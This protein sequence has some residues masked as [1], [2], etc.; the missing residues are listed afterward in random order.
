MIKNYGSISNKINHI[1]HGAD[2]NPE[3]W[4]HTPHV[5]EEDYK[6][7]KL[8]N[9]N[10]M[11]VNVFGWS[12]IE[13]EEGVYNFESLDNTLDN[14]Y[15]NGIYAIIATPSGA[16]PNWLSKKYEETNRVSKNRVRHLAGLRHNHCFTSHVYREKVKN[17]NTLIA[18]RYKN[19]P[20]LLMWH[21]SNEYEGEC[22]C[23]LCQNAFREWL[24]QKYDNSLEKL[25][26]AWWTNFWS[27][28]YTSWDEIESPSPIGEKYVHG[29]N[30]D[31]KR[32]V[33]YQ[34]VDF[35]KKEI[36]V[37][38]EIAP[39][40]P[41]TTNT[42]DYVV[43][44]RGLNY[45]DF[46]PHIDVISWDNYPRWHEGKCENWK[47]AVKTG[48]IHDI[49]RSLKNGQPFMMMESS[50]SA[51]NWQPVA[52]LR[53]PG[54]QNL[55]S[56]QAVA[57]GSDTVQYFQWRKSLGSFEKFHGAVV[58]HYA[59]TNTRVFKE[60]SAIGEDLKKLDG[61]IGTSVEPQ[62][63]II[64]DWENFW[65]IDDSQA[66]NEKRKEYFQTCVKHYT[67]FWKRGI[68]ANVI[69]MDC[70]LSKYKMVI[71][72]MLYMI[73]DGVGEKIEKFVKIGGVFVTTYWSGIV[74]ET[75][76][77]FTNG[78]PGPLKKVMGIWSEEIDA[79]Y[80]GEF[81]IVKMISSE[82]EYKAEV[83]CDL[84]HCEG[85]IKL[86]EYKTDFYKGYP[87]LT[88]NEFGKGYGYYIASRNCEEF[89]NDFYG[90][91]IIKHNI[92]PVMNTTLPEGVTINV[93][94]DEKNTFYFMQNYT[95]NDKE[96]ILDDDKYVNVLTKNKVGKSIT[97]PGYS[98]KILE[99]RNRK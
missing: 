86:A 93:R 74:N 83:F 76:L 3:Q 89:L 56:M 19:H 5:I 66:P 57:H 98:Y 62:V 29:L 40:I 50:P 42:H 87:A 47:S 24:K 94:E 16:R 99:K 44:E 80:D 7:M 92:K 54:M 58:G 26:I 59:T 13:P 35:M 17:I 38:K 9:C 49:N 34:T 77:A 81:N 85:A 31:W 27:H 48:F 96:I 28:T 18:K 88:V 82:C 52:K 60:V 8:A 95:E 90:E 70:D 61:V 2:Y 68:S 71:A 78:R 46:A 30:I 43:L 67:E 65:G 51:T 6:L 75:D 10:V 22:H 32:F 63:A 15:K 73:K 64:Y 33:T 12:T 4:L 21:V 11:T 39:D 55:A 53:R 20:A 41:V 1:L 23:E 91:L 37:L 97:L 69:S 79:L 36:E 14:L 25:N 45:W 84:I 72:P